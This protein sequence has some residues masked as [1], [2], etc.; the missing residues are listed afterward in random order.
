MHKIL[1]LLLLTFKRLPPPHK[2]RKVCRQTTIK[3]KIQAMGNLAAI[4]VNTMAAT[5]PK[6]MAKD[7]VMAV[8]MDAVMDIPMVVQPIAVQ[9]TILAKMFAAMI[10]GA[11]IAIMNHAITMSNAALK[12]KCLARKDAA[13][14][15]QN[16]MRSHAADMCHSTILKQYA[17]KSLNTMMLKNAKPASAGFANVSAS[18][19]H[20]IIGNMFAVKKVATHLALV[21]SIAG[22]TVQTILV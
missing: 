22:C 18:M 3:F 12:S 2:A 14:C 15:A 1:Q 16:I 11:C 4:K 7:M 8:D 6:D 13:E 20:N 17:A 10:A 21:S 9:K 19:F 5:I